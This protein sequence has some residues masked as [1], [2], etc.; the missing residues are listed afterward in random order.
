M[1]KI[2]IAL[3]GNALGENH[4]EQQELI[5]KAA[6]SIV[7]LV[8]EG[9][10]LVI[11]HGNGPQVGMIHQ[12]LKDEDMPL[13]EC[14]AMSQGYIGYHLQK[15]ILNEL[16]R[17]NLDI[18]VASI[19][20]QV[21][22]DENDLAFKEPTK[23]IGR[24]YTEEEANELAE[25]FG[26]VMKE[27]A[28]RGYRRFVPSPR[29]KDIV[30][31]KEILGFIENKGIV[32]ASGGGGIPVI[33]NEKG[34]YGVEA[35]IDK[36]ATSALMADLLD[37]DMFLILTA[38]DYVMINFG[39]ENQEALKNVKVSQLREYIKEDQFHKG[40]MLP[41]IEAAIDFVGE[42]D[43]RLC[44]ITELDNALDAIDGKIGTK[45]LA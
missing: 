16:I 20:T 8:K 44:I 38:I 15:G 11:C 29:P 1:A 28:G 31:K 36:D 10:D 4:I 17:N 22:V 32:I 14:T 41:K 33:K 42:K 6:K 7:D 26:Y 35:V 39:K 5:D 9:H 12:N 45:I 30:E 37:V 25:K 43:K 27:D 24:F 34:L 3:G 18:R 13:Q 2:L 21:E 23:P 40:S 19:V